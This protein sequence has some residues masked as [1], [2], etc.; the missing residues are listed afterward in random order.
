MIPRTL[1]F[2]LI[3]GFLALFFCHCFKL[4]TR[5]PP[6]PIW[7]SPFAS[8]YNRSLLTPLADPHAF[9]P[10][11]DKLLFLA[12]YIAMMGEGT[13][14]ALFSPERLDSGRP[15]SHS[16]SID[17]HGRVLV[18]PANDTAGIMALVEKAT[19][20]PRTSILGSG[21]S[22]KHD[23][24]CM[25][26]DILYIP[27][28][29]SLPTVTTANTSKQERS[30]PFMGTTI[31][32]HAFRIHE[33]ALQYPHQGFTELPDTLWELF[34]LIMEADA[35]SREPT[36]QVVLAKLKKLTEELELFD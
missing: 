17:G 36:D 15:L 23:V 31:N 18:V 9:N 33:K 3:C 7:S 4:S 13:T 14:L 2:S 29:R 5:P 19:A 12:Y 20:L 1:L 25:P 10:T 24:T 6:S 26:N 35:D 8:W 28:R 32:V 27:A 16:I 30:A 21:W 34:G 11:Q 22:V